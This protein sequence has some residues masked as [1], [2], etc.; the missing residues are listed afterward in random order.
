MPYHWFK[1]LGEH[2]CPLHIDK[3]KFKRFP[4]YLFMKCEQEGKRYKKLCYTKTHAAI[5]HMYRTA[6][7]DIPKCFI[8]ELSKFI[9][10]MR[11]TFVKYIQQ[12]VDQCGL[13]K[14]LLSSPIYS[15]TCQIIYSSHKNGHVFSRALFTM[16]WSLVESE[17]FFTRMWA[18]LNGY[19]FI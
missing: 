16:E 13:W 11:I 3:L 2:S 4:Y 12:M 5:M 1:V 8:S 7:V 10:G 14:S 17:N 19:F 6:K 18:I 9:Y 15:K